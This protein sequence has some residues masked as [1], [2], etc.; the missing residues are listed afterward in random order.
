MHDLVNGFDYGLNEECYMYG[1][2][3]NVSGPVDGKSYD[4]SWLFVKQNKAMRIVEYPFE[5]TKNKKDSD[6][7]S[8]LA[9]ST[10]NTIC[11]DSANNRFNT[12]FIYSACH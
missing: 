6:I 5:Y 10:F 9:Y 12:A 3:T 8:Q 2:C 7:K 1:E 11:A 4:G